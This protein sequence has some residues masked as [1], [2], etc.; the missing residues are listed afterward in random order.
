MRM[1]VIIDFNTGIEINRSCLA[2]GNAPQLNDINVVCSYGSIL[3][4]V[5]SIAAPDAGDCPEP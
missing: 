1:I 3:Q 4:D 5:E 2:H